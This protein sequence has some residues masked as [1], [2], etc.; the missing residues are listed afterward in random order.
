[1]RVMISQRY[2]GDINVIY[3]AVSENWDTS[4]FGGVLYILLS[5]LKPLGFE[6]NSLI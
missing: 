5:D 1:M 4:G 6:A 3:V 2:S